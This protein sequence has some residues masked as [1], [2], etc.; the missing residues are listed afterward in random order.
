MNLSDD[1]VKKIKGL[2]VFAVV[3]VIIG[4]NWALCLRLILD[5]LGVFTP[6][7]IGGCLAFVMNIPMSFIESKLKA[8]KKPGA[9]RA[10][11]I[12]IT[13]LCTLLIIMFVMLMVIPE[14]VI[15]IR[16]LQLSIP[17]FF[18]SASDFITDFINRY[19]EILSAFND[20]R[21]DWNS[22]ASSISSCISGSL[23]VIL[24]G[25]VT[26]LAGIA[27]S[28]TNG[29][30]AFI[31]ALYILIGKEKL[32]RQAKA[33]L[34]AFTSERR[35]HMTL[36]VM[37]LIS[38][39]FSAFVTGQCLEACILGCMFVVTLSIVGMPYAT[40]IGVLVAVTA[41][42]PVFGAFIGCVVGAF[43]VLMQSPVMALVFIV[44]FLVIQQ[45]EGNLIYPHVVGGRVDLPAIWVLVAVTSGGA[46]FGVMGMIAFI[47]VFSVIY[48][49][50]RS[51]VR[52]RNEK[53]REESEEEKRDTELSAAI[54][55]VSRRL[56]LKNDEDSISDK[57]KSEKS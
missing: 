37:R 42:I 20:V 43:L 29:V 3:A 40:L 57:E 56:G 4:T 23:S 47:P 45:I 48:A 17:G 22:V 32:T 6:F 52:L 7:I 10:L 36:A 41:L 28:V 46:F 54:K 31:F 19:P 34:R 33:A 16:S 39:K 51:Y 18:D 44:I 14:L 2:I 5:V 27:S 50:L 49:L 21:I 53:L 1:T 35:Y 25:T 26:A 11:G 12:I 38:G 9:R 13:L 24:P 55:D 15:S 30:I 8:V